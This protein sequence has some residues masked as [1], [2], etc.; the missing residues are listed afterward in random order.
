MTIVKAS[1]VNDFHTI[2]A[3]A[4]KIIPEFYAD[5]IPHDHNI[6]FVKKFQTVAAIQEQLKI[7][8]E[9]YLFNSKDIAVG[10][11]GLLVNNEISRMLL[12]KLYLL[13]EYRG[14]GYG[15][16]A[17]NFIIKHS[18]ELKLTKITLT[19]NREKEKTIEF[20]KKHGF[21]ITKEL[22]NKFENG[23]TILDYEMTRINKQ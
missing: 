4:Y 6:F 9:Y 19:V 3:L 5:V 13:K 10:Y 14:L 12:S 8:Y 18:D 16:K 7:G 11:F 1:N 21:S 22:V 2:E 17:L 15:T 20:Y 23:Y